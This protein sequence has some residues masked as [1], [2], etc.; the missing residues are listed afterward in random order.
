MIQPMATDRLRAAI[1]AGLPI[2]GACRGAT[3]A[4]AP[5]VPSPALVPGSPD[6]SH[7]PEENHDG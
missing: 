6:A 5:A 7:N 2:A 4:A 1:A 3:S